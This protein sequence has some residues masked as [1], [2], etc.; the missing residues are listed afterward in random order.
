[1]FTFLVSL[2]VVLIAVK[3]ALVFSVCL[4]FKLISAIL[5]GNSDGYRDFRRTGSVVLGIPVTV[6]G[7]RSSLFACLQL[8][9]SHPETQEFIFV[10]FSGRMSWMH[11]PYGT[12]FQKCDW[13][14]DQR[15]ETDCIFLSKLRIYMSNSTLEKSESSL[16]KSEELRTGEQDQITWI[17]ETAMDLFLRLWDLTI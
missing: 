17:R 3:W 12:F 9:T 8:S 14:V 15:E 2:A 11:F 4:S 16:L 5:Q 10:A 1:M 13:C 6:W 7:L